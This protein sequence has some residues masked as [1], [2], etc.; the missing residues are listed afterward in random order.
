MKV[1]YVIG[2]VIRNGERN[3][4]KKCG[5]KGDGIMKDKVSV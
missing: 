1:K 2:D 5:G 3:R 4:K